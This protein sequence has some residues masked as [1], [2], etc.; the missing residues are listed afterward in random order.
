MYRKH[1]WVKGEVI[2]STGLNH[3]EDGIAAND[4]AIRAIH[5]PTATSELLNDSGYITNTVNNLTNYT[6][7]NQLATVATSGN[8]NDLTNKPTIPT[9]T[10]DLVNDSGFLTA[11]P[12]DYVTDTELDQKGYLT[13][14]DL[15]DY[16]QTSSLANVAFSG[17]YNDLEDKPIIPEPYELPTAS[18][19]VL[20]GVKIDGTSI[21]IQDGV[22]SAV[23]GG[24]PISSYDDLTDKPQIN[25]VTLQGNITLSDIGVQPAGDYATQSDIP[26]NVSQLTNDSGY[27]TNTVLSDYALKSELPTKTSE[28]QNDSGYLT[29]IPDNYVTSD[30]LSTVATTGNYNDLT[31]KPDIPEPYILPVASSTTLGGVKIDNSTITIKNEVISANIPENITTQGNTFNGPSQLVQLDN[32][33]KLPALDGSQLTGITASLPS[34]VVTTDTE[35]NI[36]GDKT[37]TGKSIYPN[38]DTVEFSYSDLDDAGTGYT[39][40]LSGPTLKYGSYNTPSSAHVIFTDNW[41][42]Y[43]N[44]FLTDSGSKEISM[45]TYNPYVIDARNYLTNCVLSYTTLPT[46]EGTESLKFYTGTTVKVGAGYLDEDGY[47]PYSRTITLQSD[48]TLNQGRFTGYEYCQ[49]IRYDGTLW[50]H[51]YPYIEVYDRSMVPTSGKYIAYV[52]KENRTFYVTDGAF[53]TSSNYQM[54]LISKTY[55]D[56]TNFYFDYA[57]PAMAPNQLNLANHTRKPS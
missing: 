49:Y 52:Y 38:P 28:L 7:T 8:Y 41:S 22:I 30:E 3:I 20:G 26:T 50:Q 5:V 21:V 36:T 32:S 1:T 39:G 12:D 24:T 37:F 53:N 23:T 54:F 46:V 17:S 44:N 42:R 2:S 14:A 10:S 45:A 56:G 48:M 13:S 51:Y 34:N 29:S 47:T 33:G 57:M 55:Y 19:T 31:N 35:Q 27:I 6:L 43:E 40:T 18:T 25:N 9:K 11:I 16:V 4:A 15:T